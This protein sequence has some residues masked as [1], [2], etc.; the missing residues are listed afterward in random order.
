MTSQCNTQIFKTSPIYPIRATCAPIFFFYNILMVNV[1]IFG[2]DKILRIS[3]V[4]PVT[5]K[6]L[7]DSLLG[8]D[9][10]GYFKQL[11]V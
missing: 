7:Y 1:T 2:G 6:S 4:D 9:V 10:Y 5:F 11:Y 3:L 8:T